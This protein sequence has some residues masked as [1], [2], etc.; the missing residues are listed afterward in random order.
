VLRKKQEAPAAPYEALDGAPGG[1]DAQRQKKAH[2]LRVIVA[3]RR[4][5]RTEARLRAQ[6]FGVDR[7]HLVVVG[8]FRG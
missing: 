7:L 1:A 2:L 8:Q 6:L 4:A 3:V 5:R